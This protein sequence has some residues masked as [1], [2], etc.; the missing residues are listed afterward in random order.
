MADS[1]HTKTVAKPNFFSRFLSTLQAGKEKE[2][3]L[4][5]YSKASDDLTEIAFTDTTYF[6]KAA[7]KKQ[8]E[9]LYRNNWAVK[10]CINVRASMMSF[11]GLKIVCKSDKS[12]IVIDK[13]LRRMHPTRPMLALQQSFRN[14]SINADIFPFAADELLFSPSGT[15][16][17]PVDP[18][19]AKSLD[20]FTAVHPINIDFIREMDDKIKFEK[21]G[22]TPVGWIF[23]RDPD[24]DYTGGTKLPLGRVAH[25]SYNKV[26][27]EIFG[28]SSIEPVYKTAERHLKV[29]EGIAH[30]VITYGNPTRDF[31][32]GDETHPATKAMMDN[33]ATEVKGFNFKSEYVHPN[34]IRVGQ[35]ESFSLGKIPNY[36]S[37]FLE[38]ISGN[39]EVPFFVL[40]GKG[41]GANKATAQ[42]IVDFVYQTIEPL[43]QAQAMYFEESIL[44]PLMRLNNI[45]EVPT[46]E[47]NEILP[48]NLKDYANVIKSLSSVMI[49][50]KQMLSM[51]EARELAGLGKSVMF[52][53]T[54]G[55]EL[56]EVRGSPGILLVKPHGEQ[57]W[58]GKKKLIVKAKEFPEMINRALYLVSDNKVYGIIKLK[59]PTDLTLKEFRAL[60]KDHLISEDERV[61]W[62]PDANKLFA[63]KFTRLKMFKEPKDYTV[64]KGVQNFI[65]EVKI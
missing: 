27:D 40:T 65:K 53:K 48:K 42:V 3:S 22:I 12:K 61:K 8:L 18:S 64:E 26:G 7:G 43:Q 25:L 34:H 60:R 41:E 6:Q 56:A 49:G 32:V 4:T 37:P 39:F 2:G 16:E 21:D 38:A 45:E 54:T 9:I 50:G 63:F 10:K 29:E 46:I 35:I 14:R 33:V 57:L 59:E 47:W 62:W 30:G 13:F 17:K 20:G 36:I 28:M 58:K 19:K 1:K 52:K 24:G 23:K 5:G 31:I 55:A 11:R 44:S 15:K 51:E